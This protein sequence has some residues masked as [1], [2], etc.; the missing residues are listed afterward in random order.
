[1][2]TSFSKLRLFLRNVSTIHAV[3]P[4]LP[5]TLYASRV[6]LFVQASELFTQAVFQRASFG[7]PKRWKS[8]GAKSGLLGEKATAVHTVVSTVRSGVAL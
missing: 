8:E 4:P 2:G 3:F 5:E 7:G 6:K 1:M